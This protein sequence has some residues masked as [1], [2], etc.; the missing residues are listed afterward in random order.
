M[1]AVGGTATDL[2]RAARRAAALLFL[3]TAAIKL[4]FDW[5]FGH[6][7]VGG[8]ISIVRDLGRNYV[9]LCAAAGILAL[10]AYVVRNRTPRMA[11]VLFTASVTL[12]FLAVA[13]QPRQDPSGRF[14]LIITQ[15]AAYAALIISPRLPSV[16]M[17]LA[18]IAPPV[19]FFPAAAMTVGLILSSNAWRTD[20][21]WIKSQI[22][23]AKAPC[24]NRAALSGDPLANQY[25]WYTL[26]LSLI[27]QDLRPRVI[28][29]TKSMCDRLSQDRAAMRVL[30]SDPHLVYRMRT[31]PG[32]IDL[33]KAG[34]DADGTAS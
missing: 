14:G 10:G 30:D 34:I 28:L 20:V 19:A 23:S 33:T 2:P 5:P 12:P 3:A 24:L 31:A 7:G 22:E 8:P 4:V 21:A 15:S 11:T 29:T 16:R 26:P 6:A 32:R 25:D 18:S 13:I 17:F 9:L 1:A 27:E